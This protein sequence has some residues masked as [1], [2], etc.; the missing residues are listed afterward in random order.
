MQVPDQ[1]HC[2]ECGGMCGRLTQRPHDDP[3]E[4]GDIVAYRC[5]DCLERFDMEL[6]NEDPEEFK[7]ENW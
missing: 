4:P 6:A 2:V 5:G 1:I 7:P 3:F